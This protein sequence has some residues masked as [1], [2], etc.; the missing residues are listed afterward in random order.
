MY[1]QLHLGSLL[2][3]KTHQATNNN[4]LPKK[5]GVT[6]AGKQHKTN[7]WAIMPNTFIDAVFMNAY[8]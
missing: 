3:N 1:I 2:I 5:T 4:A 8:S 6:I 7:V